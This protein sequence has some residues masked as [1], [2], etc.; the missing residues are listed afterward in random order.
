MRWLR[1]KLD[2]LGNDAGTQPL[3][4][5][6][7]I[8]DGG[9]VIVEDKALRLAGTNPEG[10]TPIRDT[11]VDRWGE[12]DSAAAVVSSRIRSRR[13]RPCPAQGAAAAPAGRCSC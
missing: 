2:V 11:V 1:A 3:Q 4:I 9:N 12:A 6:D 13:V 8:A 10:L 5:I 7:A